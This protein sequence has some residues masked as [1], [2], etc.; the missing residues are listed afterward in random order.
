MR[1]CADRRVDAPPLRVARPSMPEV[2][3]ARSP[4]RL[5]PRLHW[6][7]AALIGVAGNAPAYTIAVGSAA[8]LAAAGPGA[9]AALLLCAAV[10]LGILLAYARLNAEH[11]DAGAAYAWVGA[12]LHPVAGFFAG[13]CV[14]MS[15]IIFMISGLLPA[16]KATLLILAPAYAGHKSL[17]FAL[18][19]GWLAVIT[20]IV[21]RGTELLGRVQSAMTVLELGLLLL[22]VAGVFTSPATFNFAILRHGLDPGSFTP[23]GIAKGLV[24]AVFIYWGWDV[25]FNLGEETKDAETNS[26][27][28]GILALLLLTAVFV[29]FA[30]LVATTL[31][32]GDLEA[33]GGNALFVLADRLLPKPLGYLA[34]LAFLLSVLGGM[35][36][37]IV[38]FSRTVLANARDGRLPRLFGR[39]QSRSGSPAIATVLGSGIVLVLLLISAAFQTVDEAI[40]ASIDATSIV[41]AAYYAM[42]ALACAAFF[43]RKREPRAH[44]VAIYVV[45]P[46]ASAAIFLGAALITL[47]DLSAPALSVLSLGVALGLGVLGITAARRSTG[48]PSPPAP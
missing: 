12:H 46:L 23:E 27:R 38:S 30:A 37:S 43:R 4:A 13:W 47:I 20:A 16:G 35:E 5:T 29:F 25:I 14:M 42:A 18:A 1:A 32:P 41:V 48:S 7:Q 33:A 28:A 15:S 11:P 36:A 2:H 24:V 34:V 31:A 17:V 39:L 10:T 8:L 26:A 40:S 45:W 9:P 6:V 21:A 19:A 22:I 44:A 3:K